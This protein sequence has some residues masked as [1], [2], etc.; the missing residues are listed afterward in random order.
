MN[1]ED[2]FSTGRMWIDATPRIT[3]QSISDPVFMASLADELDTAEWIGGAT[4]SEI[5]AEF[6][7]HNRNGRRR[8]TTTCRVTD[9]DPDRRFAYDVRLRARGPVSVSILVSRWQYD[10]EPAHD[11]STVTIRSWV[12][13]PLWFIPIALSFSGVVNRP[14]ANNTH[15]E[16]QLERLKD[17]LEST[18]TAR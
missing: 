11:G 14:G 4:R 3:F 9:L 2:P 16:T 7:G 15:I 18:R 10:I 17:H 6:L 12:R 5:G 13:M 1:L 8:W